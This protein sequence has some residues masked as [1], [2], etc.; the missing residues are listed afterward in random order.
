MF[1]ERLLSNQKLQA[2]IVARMFGMK[3]VADKFATEV[4]EGSW[5]WKKL[6]FNPLSS[7]DLDFPEISLN[8]L[9][10]LFTGTYQLEQA[11]AYLGEIARSEVMCLI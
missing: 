1:G 8:D 3:N 7:N 11:I 2:E 10:I 5:N 9:K 6:P 4:E